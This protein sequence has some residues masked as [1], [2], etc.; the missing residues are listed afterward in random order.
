MICSKL[1]HE[2]CLV[3][4]AFLFQGFNLWMI[5][6]FGNITLIYFKVGC[7]FHPHIYAESFLSATL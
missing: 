3:C 7:I 6:Q 4:F 2:F 5:G 1:F